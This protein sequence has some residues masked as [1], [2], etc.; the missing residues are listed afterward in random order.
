[1]KKSAIILG[2]IL[3]LVAFPAVA[4]ADS[5]LTSTQFSIAY[6][7][8]EV[9]K[10]AEEKGIVT[11]GIADYLAD[12]A[13]PID[14]KA[15]VIN[16]LSWD[17]NGK[18]N[19]YTYSQMVY[20]E[21]PEDLNIEDLSG[22]QQFCIGYLMAMDDYNNTDRALEILKLAEKNV[23]DSFTVSIIR[24]LVESMDLADSSWE[25]HIKP[26]LENG[27][28]KQDMRQDAVNIILDYMA[29]YSEGN[30]LNVSRT[31]VKIEKGS[32]ESVYL[33]GTLPWSGMDF[34]EI[35]KNSDIADAEICW[36]DYG[37]YYLKLTGNEVGSSSIE[38]KN[39]DGKSA[40]ISLEVIPQAAQETPDV[41]KTGVCSMWKLYAGCMAAA[42]FGI[43]LTG[44]E[45]RHKRVG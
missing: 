39:S 40:V 28:L 19:T 2:V 36:D 43:L 34:Y 29:L 11:A 41:P 18:T 38:I 13:N 32:S 21:S 31:N 44:M 23:P 5:P 33:Y 10:E 17:L 42:A 30:E 24:A 27:S 16:A 15:A 25:E 1:M 8:M 26:I 7:D 6:E 22:D 4:S 14:I 3:A 45:A 37:V 35:V 20:D 12:E 9:V